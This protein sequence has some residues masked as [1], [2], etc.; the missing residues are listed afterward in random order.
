MRWHCNVFKKLFTIVVYTSVITKEHA[1][2]NDNIYSIYGKAGNG[3]SYIPTQRPSKS[4]VLYIIRSEF[5]S[6]DS[7]ITNV[8]VVLKYFIIG[9]NQII[10]ALNIVVDVYCG[11]IMFWRR[12]ELTFIVRIFIIQVMIF[13]CDV[14]HIEHLKYL[15]N[16]Y[17]KYFNN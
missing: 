4:T 17:F 7:N 10:F 8:A 11:V 3:N 13:A 12:D 16:M 14:L 6:V 5:G 1:S 15:L 2:C 9:I